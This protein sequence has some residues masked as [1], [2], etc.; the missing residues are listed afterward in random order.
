MYFMG[1]KSKLQLERKILS[2]NQCLQ[3]HPTNVGRFFQTPAPFD[4]KQINQCKI[5]KP[6][7][8]TKARLRS[9]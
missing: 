1:L 8:A 5:N 7:P 9:K 2:Q 4:A 6:M 3:Q